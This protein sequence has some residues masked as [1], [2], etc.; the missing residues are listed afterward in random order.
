MTDDEEILKT[1]RSVLAQQ[2]GVQGDVSSGTRLAEDLG[3]DSTGLLALALELENHYQ[4][5]LG[6]DPA[7][8]P[9]SVGDVV[10]LISKGLQETGR[11]TVD[12]D[13]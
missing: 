9:R 8:P 3:L 1:V 12:R 10:G 2:C 11:S 7:S 5:Q 6:E 4:L 13:S